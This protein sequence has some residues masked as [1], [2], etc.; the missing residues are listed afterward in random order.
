MQTKEGRIVKVIF[1][2]RENGYTVAIFQ[3]KEDEITVTGNFHAVNEGTIYKL[4]GDF[5]IHPKYGEQFRV[6]S[7][8]ERVP[9]DSEGIRAFLASGAIRGIGPKAADLIVDRFGESAL[10]VIE[11]DPDKLLA[12]KGIGSKTL[13]KIID[14][15]NESREFTRIAFELSGYGITTAH[16][17]KIYNEYG[18][19]SVR[20]V[21]ENPYCLVGDVSGIGFRNADRIA[22]KIGI[23]PASE[24]RVSS[25]IR[26]VLQTYANSGSIFVPKEIAARSAA[27]LLNLT[28]DVIEDTMVQM[29]FN[30]D[31]QSD[32]VDDLNVIYL[33]DYY[34]SE[35]RVAWDIKRL[36]NADVSPIPTSDIDNFISGIQGRMNILRDNKIELSRAQRHAV[37][38]ALKNNICIIT[39]GPG[40]GKTTIINFIASIFQEID[41]KT[42]IAAPTGRAAK[43]ITE[44]SGFPAKTI[45]R[46]LG[47]SYTEDDTMQF[48]K[49]EE[50]P[51]EE[52]AIIVDEA[53]MIDL[54]LME[55]LLRAISDGSRLIIVGD[56]DQ[57]PSVGAGNVLRD[58]INS[59]CIHSVQLKEIFRQAGESDIVVNAHRINEGKYPEFSGRTGD[60]F[61]MREDDEIFVADRMVELVKHRL[62]EYYDFIHSWHDIQVITPTKKGRLGTASLNSMLQN[63]L[64]PQEEGKHE[65]KYG[66]KVF[67]EGD[68][69]MQITNNYDMEWKERGGG[70]L[71]ASYTGRGIFNGDMGF[72]ESIDNEYEKITVNFDGRIVTYDND[73]IEE[74]ELAYAITVHK[75]QGSEFPAVIMPMTWF[76]P[77]LMTRNLLYTGVTRGKKLVVIIGNESRMRSMVDNNRTDERYTG[78]AYRLK[79][80]Y[81]LSSST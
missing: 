10:E 50:S 6:N 29:V 52:K 78:L 17:I 56:A 11:S 25:G 12:I 66:V 51:L 63:A 41:I 24:F 49:N 4:R 34:E 62:A 47:Y 38:D 14:S 74:L 23:E 7:Y 19:E 70:Y 22:A 69:V 1:N 40:T 3:T 79:G 43:R 27:D 18:A 55:G 2:N 72:I 59:G 39:G 54:K 61:I 77:M 58:M 76:P 21:E 65:K 46:M 16:A 42:S 73:N 71:E 9:E 37:A 75:S 81:L 32:I 53:S 31:I 68:K 20:T 35:Q 45:H 57:L 30:G 26:Y 5:N 80:D 67:R 15:Y 28:E 33:Y 48:G 44:T 13:D 64:N 8:E 36:M 60:F